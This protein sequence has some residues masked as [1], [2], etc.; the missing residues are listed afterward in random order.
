MTMDKQAVPR[1][2]GWAPKMSLWMALKCLE[3]FITEFK[4]KALN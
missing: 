2:M 1:S 3:F 4:V